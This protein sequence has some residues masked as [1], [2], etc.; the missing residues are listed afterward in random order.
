MS[1][2]LVVSGTVSHAPHLSPTYCMACYPQGMCRG[3]QPAQLALDVEEG[4][5]ADMTC[6]DYSWCQ[7]DD[8]CNIRDA[9]GHFT[10]RDQSAKVPDC[11]CYFS[12]DKFMYY[13]DRGTDTF[14]ISLPEVSAETFRQT[15]KAHLMDF[16]PAIG[17]YVVLQNFLSG[18]H[19][20]VNGGV[21][22]DRADY[23]SY[24]EG[25]PLTF[26]DRLTLDSEGLHAVTIVGWGVAKNV[27]YDNE[28][29]GDVPFWHCRNSWGTAWG[30][31]GYFKIAM[32]PFNRVAQFDK[33]VNVTLNRQVA[34]IG[35]MIMIRATTAPISESKETINR[36]FI[37]KINKSK[38]D[39]YYDVDASSEEVVIPQENEKII[40][41]SDMKSDA[42]YGWIALLVLICL[43]LVV[44]LKI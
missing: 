22:F 18:K 39:A 33:V 16:G 2:C 26:D 32:Y 43:I 42:T 4:G 30:D 12:N 6:L 11:G 19:T 3:G 25:S 13:L 8:E 15:V 34:R 37:D 1:D 44:T 9:S 36:R 40:I 24:R 5:V 35:G 21:Y 29:R 28:A 14:S 20:R 17:G 27:L 38:E 31:R 23:A 7:N 41:T 10:A